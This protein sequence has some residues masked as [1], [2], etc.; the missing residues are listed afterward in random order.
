MR[1]ILFGAGKRGREMLQSLGA[2]NVKLFF[3]NSLGIIGKDIEG[4]KICHFD[5]YVSEY[6]VNESVVICV[7]DELRAVSIAVQLEEAGIKDYIYWDE[8]GSG[9]DPGVLRERHARRMADLYCGLYKK[10]SAEKDYLRAHFR[11]QDIT[12]ATGFLR[13]KQLR[14]VEYARELLLELHKLDIHPI[15]S[16]GNL[17]GLVRNGGFLPWDDDIDLKLLRGEYE[18]LKEY[19]KANFVYAK[20]TGRYR[21]EHFDEYGNFKKELFERNPDRYILL[22]TPLHIQIMKGQNLFDGCSIDLFVIDSY[23]DVYDFATHW[24]RLMQLKEEITASE[25]CSE[26][27]DA[28]ERFI[29]E[30]RKFWDE[31]GNNLFYGA[32]N[33]ESYAYYLDYDKW[34]R[35]DDV[36][37]LG[38]AVYET[39]VFYVP[40]HREECVEYVFGR[41]WRSLPEKIGVPDHSYWQDFIMSAYTCADIIYTDKYNILCYL[42]L[43]EQ[44]RKKNIYA[45]IVFPGKAE[46][47]VTDTFDVFGAEISDTINREADIVYTDEIDAALIYHDPKVIRYR[48]AGDGRFVTEYI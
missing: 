39:G 40:A 10:V 28:I 45:R 9:E 42:E 26:E 46:R 19:C 5:K 48:S 24:E 38:E 37:P 33:V 3:D 21:D 30:D 22:E 27:Y 35:R 7:E 15:L 11:P 25:N 29:D 47:A 14:L 20:Y 44:L 43:Y 31:D 17:L 32:D 34:L 36:F 2:E 12:P 18:R 13:K 41:N 16:A 23:K 4:I 1:Y 6:P 8:A